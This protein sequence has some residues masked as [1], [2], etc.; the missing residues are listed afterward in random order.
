MAMFIIG[1]LDPCARAALRCLQVSRRPGRQPAAS[2]P[3]PN[4]DALTAILDD[5]A[6]VRQQD[7]RKDHK[8][9]VMR[10]QVCDFTSAGRCTFAGP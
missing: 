7:A 10:S 2:A 9:G 3:S 4:P 6:Q 5:M 1:Y 8:G